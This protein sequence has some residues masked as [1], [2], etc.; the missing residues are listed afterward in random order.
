MG[1]VGGAS[2]HTTV[3][4]VPRFVAREEQRGP[5]QRSAQARS[6]EEK[7]RP[8]EHI[9]FV[10]RS[11]GGCGAVYESQRDV[12]FVSHWCSRG[13]RMESQVQWVIGVV[14]IGSISRLSVFLPSFIF[15]LL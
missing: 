12:D 4:V 10:A 9:A 13:G 8:R 11:W 1:S 15:G 6:R 14:F 3:A 5:L 7:N 2:G